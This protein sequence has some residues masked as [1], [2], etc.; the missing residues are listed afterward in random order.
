MK[1]Y[2]LT[3]LC[4][5]L[6]AIGGMARQNSY[7]IDSD[8]ALFYAEDFIAQDIL[9]SLTVKEEP[10]SIG[11]VPGDW[12]IVPEFYTENSKGRASISY[13]AIPIIP[14]RG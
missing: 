6:I 2:I 13:A 12:P 5:L 7:L 11:P 14:I 9:P 10:D 4:S 1:H 3:L 8:I